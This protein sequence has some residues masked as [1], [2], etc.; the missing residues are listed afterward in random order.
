MG[1][2]FLIPSVQRTGESR[3][4][5]TPPPPPHLSAG[6]TAPPAPPGGSP[7]RL[8][9]RYGRSTPPAAPPPM[10]RA[11]P[12]GTS[13]PVPAGAWGAAPAGWPAAGA[14]PPA[15]SPAATDLTDWRRLPDLKADNQQRNVVL[16]LKFANGKYA[17]YTLS[18]LKFQFHCFVVVNN[19]FFNNRHVSRFQRSKNLNLELSIL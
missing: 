2:L 13:P 14:A 12:H 9:R 17:F 16:P 18:K 5:A 3:N 8:R 4:S 6:R 1:F 15:P 7:R 19:I 11:W 10:G